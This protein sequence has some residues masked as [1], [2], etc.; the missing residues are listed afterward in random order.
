MSLF[1]GLRS[2]LVWLWFGYVGRAATFFGITVVLG[3]ALGTQGYGELA[4][5]LGMTMGV[6]QLTG[7]WP[8]LSMPVLHARGWSIPAVY[9]P[10]V[11]IAT[12]TTLLALSIV[13]PLAYLLGSTSVVTALA[14]LVYSSALVGMQ[15]VYGAFQAARRMAGIAVSQTLE[16]GLT[17]IV[18]L[19][20]TTFFT[21]GLEQT[22]VLI[23]SSSLIVLAGALVFFDRKLGPLRLA[24]GEAS[25]SRVLVLK[26][27]GAMGVVS[28][29]AYGVAWMD[30]FMVDAFES[31]GV[32]GTYTLAYQM[33][34]FVIQIGSLWAVATLPRHSS[35]SADGIRLRSQVPRMAGR[36]ASMVW[37]GLMAIGA[38][39]AIILVPLVYGS[40]FSNSVGPLAMLLAA[41]AMTLP[42]FL[43]TPAMIAT[44][45]TRHLALI[46]I[47]GLAANFF[48]NLALI[49]IIGPMG[50]AIGTL[51]Q[52]LVVTGLVV[53]LVFDRTELAGFAAPA[54][55][56]TLAL[57][58][59]AF[60]PESTILV[61]LSGVVGSVSLVFGGRRLRA[62]TR[63][64]S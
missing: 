40:Q 58:A 2:D 23:A 24:P 60:G 39:A 17:L 41:A 4:I 16:R 26:A 29:C 54:L 56:A 31:K 45:K 33:F 59:L 62:A 57:I 22:E 48:L 46:S 21:L 10:A 50:A 53:Q 42:Y 52:S 18:L 35:A 63:S 34:T 27:V 6:S 44:G 8:F 1:S 13:I 5:F 19:C 47:A 15:S 3:R 49:P 55:P 11:Q 43:I 28:A 14:I 30:I 37:A 51:A 20:A 64:V 38:A 32:V 9:R 61:L 7:S 36:P 12:M 25:A